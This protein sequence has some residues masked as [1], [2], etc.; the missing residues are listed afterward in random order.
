[1]SRW[2]DY[3]I[4]YGEES[5]PATSLWGPAA[6][7][8]GGRTAYVLGV[9]FDPRGLVGLQQFLAMGLE[10]APL[11]VRLE[12][13]PPTE[14][15]HAI[16]RT[17][18][19]DNLNSF[20]QLT[21]SIEVQTIPYPDVHERANAGPLIARALTGAGFMTEI[22]HV[23]VDISSLPST[24]Y[25]PLIAAVLQVHDEKGS[26]RE[27]QIVACENP[28]VD[29]AILEQGVT[30][31]VAVGGFR[32]YLDLEARPSGTMIWAP[33]IGE[34]CSP[35]L[36][37]IHTFLNPN[38]TTPILPFPARH[39]RRADRLV[40][41]HQRELFDEFLVNPANM[42]YADE[43]NP[44]DLYRTLSKFQDDCR[45][46]L[47]PLKPTTVALSTHSSKLLSLGVLLAACEHHLP[48][49]AAPASDYAISDDADF[50]ELGRHNKVSCMWLA[51]EPYQ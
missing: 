2:D 28:E 39:P 16:A 45:T 22:A 13:P 29:A 32:N 51:G 9:G 49:V 42:I 14:A 4:A 10:R 35:A 43:R 47:E 41:E 40:L 21:G 30:E 33:V 20:N 19:T 27:V 5:D 36:R 1:M 24:L 26:P 3:V 31:G 34:H 11:V 17:L 12:L 44:F 18:A 48:I 38:D 37:A 15:S 46:A 50:A 8:S 7:A 6:A 23:V 25:F